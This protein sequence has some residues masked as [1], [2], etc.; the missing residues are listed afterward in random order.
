MFD[1]DGLDQVLLCSE[2]ISNGKM[3]TS[4]YWLHL[5]WDSASPTLGLC[6]NT[7]GRVCV[8]G[9]QGPDHLCVNPMLK[10]LESD[11]RLHRVSET[12]MEV[13]GQK[14]IRFKV[15][16]SV[17]VCTRGSTL[18][19]WTTQPV[20]YTMQSPYSTWCCS[21]QENTVQGFVPPA[22]TPQLVEYEQK[23]H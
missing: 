9:C 11:H 19:L 2:M 7:R 17:C 6:I 15:V 4:N 21:W 18:T 13:G 1:L 20:I 12:C 3:L 14:V 10:G 22:R 5:H 8:G 16:C 23:K